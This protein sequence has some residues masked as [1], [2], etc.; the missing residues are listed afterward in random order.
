VLTLAKHCAGGVILGFCQ[1][2]TRQ[3]IEKKGTIEEK[4][5][6]HRVVFPTAW[7]QLEA[8]ILFAL[9]KPLL[10]FREEGILGGIFDNGVTD[11]FVQSMPAGRMKAKERN[12]FREIMRKF[13]SKVHNQ[14]YAV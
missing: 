3:G 13:A 12:A 1:F 7:N 10:V 14:Y 9:A 11:L 6:R 5:I 4:V 8:G 2:E